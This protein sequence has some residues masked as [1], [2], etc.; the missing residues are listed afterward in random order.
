MAYISLTSSDAAAS[1]HLP[2]SFVGYNVGS[3]APRK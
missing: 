3:R 2:A 1:F